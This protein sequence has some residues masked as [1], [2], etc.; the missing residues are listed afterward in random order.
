VDAELSEVFA[1]FPAVS[2]EGAKGVGKTATAQRLAR[3]IVPFDRPVPRSN[4]SA[5]P[6]II[7]RE[8]TP[9]LLDEW[10]LVPAVWDVVRRA[11]DD[12]RSPGRFLL[13]GSALPP[14][15]ARLHSGAGR[16]I[17]LQMR[18]MTL[19]ERG[20]CAPTV[21]LADL[22]SGVAEPQGNS[23]LGLADYVEEIIASGF[24]GIRQDPPRIRRRTLDSYIR[25][26]LE[27]EIPELGVKVRRPQALRA[28]LSAY[29]AASAKTTS[30]TKILNAATP[31]DVDKPAKKTAIVY[32]SLLERVWVLDPLPA[33]VPSFSY[34]TRLGESPKHH[35]VDPALAVSLLGATAQSL[36]MESASG[37][38]P[39]DTLLGALFESLCV[40][41]VRVFAQSLDADVSHLRTRN[42]DHEI[43]MI[44]ERAD[45]RVLAIEVKLSG[46][47]DSDDTNHLNW[48]QREIGD[49]LI[50]RVVINTGEYAYRTLDGVAV[51]PLA[52]LG[53]D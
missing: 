47:V 2:L 37:P 51:V 13:T 48:L 40:L 15:E 27:H 34:L 30:Y 38:D 42:G 26:L 53:A 10:Q 35:L 1:G 36:V 33:W 8:Q 52:L 21:S 12:D 14:E 22:L 16:I 43:D 50:D 24:P 23:Q 18:P 5:D 4:I 31:G 19:P 41:S 17:R 32:R 49:R 25:E 44:V 7:L 6:Q 20:V 9:V 39:T 46:T 3:R 29:A 11:V 28:W 45:H